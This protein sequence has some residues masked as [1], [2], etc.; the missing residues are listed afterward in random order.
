MLSEMM[1]TK[2]EMDQVCSGP[3]SRMAVPGAW[4]IYFLPQ[5]SLGPW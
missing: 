5:G 3:F 4:N 1:L 2:T